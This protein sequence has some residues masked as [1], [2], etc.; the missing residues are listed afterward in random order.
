MTWSSTEISCTSSR[1]IGGPPFED[2]GLGLEERQEA[3]FAALT[4][5]ARLLEPAEGHAEVRAEGVVA[6]GAG[7]EPT[8]HL[9][10]PVDVVREHRRVEPVDRVVGD[11][12][13]VLLVLRRDHTEDRPEDLLT[14]DRRAVVDVA[15][16]RRLHVVA[17]VEVLGASSPGGERR[18]LGHACGD[19]ALDAITLPF[20]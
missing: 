20:G 14:T 11:P 4:T 16:D 19:V 15:E 10:G 5:D 13:R 2:D 17:A 7:A 8:G 1:S 6:D 9:S 18:A 3:F 12:H